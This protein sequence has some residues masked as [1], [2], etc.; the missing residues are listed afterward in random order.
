M[1]GEH[2]WLGNIGK[3]LLL[4]S[5]FM[6]L[7][8]GIVYSVSTQLKQTD[9]ISRFKKAGKLS[10]LF[11]A[12]TLF[13]ACAILGYL[14]F[15]HYFEYAYVW[16]Y[17]SVQMPLRYTI[18]CFWAGQE[19]SFMLWGFWQALL[20]VIVLYSV[21]NN[22]PR[23][24]AIIAFAQAILLTAVMGVDFG[25]YKLGT[26][27]FTLLRD[28]P[29]SMGNA[30]FKNPNYLSSIRDGIG[31][32]PL[33]ENFWMISHPPV[34]FLGYASVL[35]PFSFALASL[36][37]GDYVNWLRNGIHWSLWSMFTLSFGIIIGGAWAYKSLTFGG[38]WAWDPVENA[39]LVPLILLIAGLH[40]LVIAQKRN[41]TFGLAYSFIIFSYV[42]VWYASFLTRSG[43]LGQTSVHAFGDDGMTLH[44]GLITGL[45]LLAGLLLYVLRYMKFPTKEGSEIV[46]DKDFFMLIGSLVLALSAFQITMT[47]SIPIWNKLFGLHVAP[48]VDPVKF[49]NSWQ[50]PYTIIVLFLVSGLQYINYR[51]H[52]VKSILNQILIAFLLSTVATIL[53][54]LYT[55]Y[56]QLLILF[57]FF[58]VILSVSISLISIINYKGRSTS[59]GSLV[60]HV[61]F[62]VFI[63]GVLLAFSNSRVI[64]NVNKGALIT[65]TPHRQDGSVVLYRDNAVKLNEYFVV[66]S[67]RLVKGTETLYQIDFYRDA[68]ITDKLFTL[69]P[70]I[71]QNEKMGAVFNPSTRN[72]IEK[73]VYSFISHAELLSADNKADSKD[74]PLLKNEISAEAINLNDFNL[75]S[76]QNIALRQQLKIGLYL[77]SLDSLWIKVKDK[78]YKD[79]DILAKLNVI[80]S[81]LSSRKVVISFLKR[82]EQYINQDAVINSWGLA[83]RFEMTSDKPN[84]INLGV[85]EH[86]ADFIVLKAIIFP[87]MNVL[88]FGALLMLAGFILSL[89]KRLVPARM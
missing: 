44:L 29:E 81:S 73:D 78:V 27:P 4:L 5:F 41:H 46:F 61:G 24:I 21:R 49:Y 52:N 26:S 32:N 6:A 77:I 16:K 86:K 23:V 62:A 31:L 22:E 69:F 42:M 76:R 67:N 36:W 39:S 8:S 40:F 64:T 87:W 38:F 75:V 48:P 7:F 83:L 47:T 28:L 18:A 63:L 51:K 35:I 56:T 66:Y 15:N 79:V 70:T 17:S 30:F 3:F 59:L 89:Y 60:S 50:I 74:K 82:G 57:L 34:L 68:K 80:N 45:F 65:K 43:I 11:H 54:A 85:Y 2:L 10:F 9:D 33:L 19:G 14:I 37:K 12:G 84:N 72:F 25:F 55:D 88:W 53:M 71:K 1:I 20:G 58:A 13:I